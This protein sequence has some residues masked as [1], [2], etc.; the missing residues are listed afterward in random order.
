MSRSLSEIYSQAKET[1]DKYLHLT[2]LDTSKMSGSK[3][4]IMNV[5]T[6]VMAVLIYT[7]ENTLDIFQSNM[8]DALS[9]R[10]NGTPQYYISMAKKFQPDGI[11]KVPDD[12]GN[13]TY[14]DPDGKTIITYASYETYPNGRGIILKVAKGENPT[15]LSSTEY[16]RFKN[17]ID[18]IKF[19]GARITVRSWP[20]DILI[21]DLRVVYD[22]N[23]ISAAE[24]I[25]NV[26]KAV[27]SYIANLG[28]DGVVY[29]SAIIDAIQAADGIVDVPST[30]HII[31]DGKSTGK[32]K[33][34]TVAIRRY[35]FTSDKYNDETEDITGWVRSASGY[36]L[37]ND[38]MN[39]GSTNT[40][41][42]TNI[43]IQSKTDYYKENTT[44]DL[45]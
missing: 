30:K 36:L 33:P 6:Y 5:L 40:F 42:T 25:V 12:G 34:S 15:P 8:V 20:G 14:A 31:V 13:P 21:P 41:D 27:T 24:A 45:E 19:V 11:L 1:R 16:A 29:E 26:Q 39:G 23:I 2:E 32:L 3:M 9:S 38:S 18:S 17:Y 4:S 7:F 44:D 37:I 43:E 22:D 35:N 28:Y 10:I